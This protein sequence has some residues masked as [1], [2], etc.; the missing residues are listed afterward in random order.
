[1]IVKETTRKPWKIISNAWK[2]KKK[3]I[4]EN[5]HTLAVTYTNI[6]LAF[7]GKG[8]IEKAEEFSKLA[9]KI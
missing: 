5:H 4:G 7:K 9:N 1:M 2:Y 6:S 3:T 8:N